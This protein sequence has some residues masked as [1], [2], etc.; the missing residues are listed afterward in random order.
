MSPL[1]TP[2]DLEERLRRFLAEDLGRGDVTAESIV[3]PD[4]RASARLLAKSDG[5]VAG[6]N[7]AE[8]VVHLLD[9]AVRASG[10]VADGGLVRRG[11]VVA[12]I[13]ADARAFL[14][15]ERT[16]LNLV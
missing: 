1:S 6:T 2:L 10:V 13:E 12:T 9:P 7:L 5:I 15:A 14:A 11:E 3:P 8:R 16:L 4:A